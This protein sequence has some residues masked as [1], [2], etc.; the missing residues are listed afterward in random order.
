MNIDII[1]NAIIYGILIGSVYSLVAIGLSLIWGVMDIVNF[2]QGDY[3][4][5]GAFITYWLLVL[6]N[7]DPLVSIIISFGIIFLL[8]VFTQRIIINRILDA[9]M[10][11]QII[12][13]FSIL[14]IIRYGAEAGFGPF[15]RWVTT[16]YSGMNFSIGS[17]SL[18]LTQ[19][20]TF[21][22]S[23]LILIILHVFLTRTYY[24]IALRAVSQNREG[25][26][27]IGINVK[28]M[29]ELAFGIGV[30]IS[31][32]GG[33]LISTF[34][35]IYPEMGGYY[36]L[37]A[38]IAVVLGGFGNVYGSYIS[39][40]ILGVIQT[41]SAVFILPTLKDV[42]AFIVFIILILIKPSGLFGR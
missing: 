16:S 18:P 26:I 21:I 1:I 19:V 32:I 7:I 9:P 8:G 13:T 42:V 2:A 29:Y 39:G 33:S 22:I 37:L 27:L 38:F 34:I 30:G 24:G 17:V 11:S 28:R 36:V 40:I 5:L 31:A 41:L 6:L 25:A 20:I 23:I 10:F 3:M 14:M 4:M 12:T 35:P 15:T